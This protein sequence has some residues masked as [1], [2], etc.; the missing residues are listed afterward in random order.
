MSGIADGADGTP[1]ARRRIAV[2]VVTYNHVRYIADCLLSVLSQDV[3]ADVTV[4]I[5]D[6]GSTDGTSESIAAIGRAWPGRVNHVVHATRQGPIGNLR[7][8]LAMAEG[9]FIAHLDGDDLWL[10]GK[11]REQLFLLD[12][13]PNCSASC[14]NAFV[15]DDARLPVGIFTNASSGILDTAFLLERG[16]FLNHSSLLYRVEHR[17]AI[18][19]LT[20]PYIDYRIL[21][22]LSLG[23]PLVYSMKAFVGYR[24]NANGS[25][26]ANANEAVRQQYFEAMEAAM[27]AVVAAVRA[28]ACADMLRRVVFR[29]ARQRRLGL[30]SAWWP[31]LL[32]ASGESRPALMFRASGFVLIEG[33]RQLIQIVSALFLRSRLRVLYFR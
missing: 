10:P 22:T 6:D 27:P 4:W 16:N 12:A 32:A 7:A 24:V 20:P 13:E 28:A 33:W 25:M 17:D 9:D 29:A 21:L 30:V 8:V 31:R 23:G 5:G 26:L 11:L 18:L 19:S 14:T 3:D 2:C 1:R 15:F